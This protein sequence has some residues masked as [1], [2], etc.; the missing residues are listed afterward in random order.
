MKTQTVK[1][2]TKNKMKTKTIGGKPQRKKRETKYELVQSIIRNMGSM[3]D[4]D[5]REWERELF[6]KKML[7][8]DGIYS[9]SHN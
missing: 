4:N 8:L 6:K 9:E 1:T 2:K 3:S 5:R 7:E